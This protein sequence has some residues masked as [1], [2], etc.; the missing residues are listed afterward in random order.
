MSNV[1]KIIEKNIAQQSYNLEQ[2]SEEIADKLMSINGTK[3][4]VMDFIDGNE[5]HFKR[6]MNLLDCLAQVEKRTHILIVQLV[7]K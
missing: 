1:N 4:A 5:A 2:K 7:D 3:E 6:Q